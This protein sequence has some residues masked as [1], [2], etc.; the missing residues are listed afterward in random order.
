M[1]ITAS[2]VNKLRQTTGAGMMDCKK[3]LE[4]TNGDFE[5]AI[6]HLRKKGQKISAKRADREANEGMI[7]ARTSDDNTKGVLVKITSETDFV[8][9]NSEF[10]QFAEKVAQIALDNF[11]ASTEELK[12]LP[13]DGTSIADA[14]DEQVAK[15]GEKIDIGEYSKIEAPS[16]VAYNHGGNRIGVLIGLNLAGSENITAAGKDAAMQIAAMNPVGIDREDVS[17]DV[18]NRELDI[19]REQIRNE[20]KAEDMVEKIA[21]GKLNKFYNDSTLM[22][23]EYVKDPSKTVKQVFQQAHPELKVTQFKRVALGE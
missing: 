21:Q 10:R 22:N 23:Q 20:G 8:A 11:P 1:A 15:I 6:D 9:K 16:V 17:Q 3:A 2:D 5:A 18:I 4:E 7:I 12:Q 14:L 13:I 19:A